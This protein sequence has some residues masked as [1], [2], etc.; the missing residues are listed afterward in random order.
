MLLV[1]IFFFKQKTA[2]ELRIS[3]WS[4]DVCSSDL[5]REL[6]AP[7]DAQVAGEGY[8][9]A[10]DLDGLLGCGQRA[11]LEV[12]GD[13]PVV[14]QGQRSRSSRG[15]EV[16]QEPPG[17]GGEVDLD[18]PGA[19]VVHGGVQVG[20]AGQVAAYGEEVQRGLVDRKST[21]LNSSH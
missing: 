7:T 13:E 17:A 9:I 12:T 16:G 3:D 15:P 8:G 2:Y 6:T 18:L 1:F 11:W 5:H 21:R 14:A 10:V 20:E 19:G 4:S